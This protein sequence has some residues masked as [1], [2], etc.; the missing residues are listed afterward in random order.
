MF[1]KKDQMLI[2]IFQIFIKILEM[3]T[4]I[5]KSHQNNKKFAVKY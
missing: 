2:S 3:F 5:I 1:L 4:F